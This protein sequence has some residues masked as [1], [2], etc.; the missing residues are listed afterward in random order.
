MITT[1]TDGSCADNTRSHERHMVFPLSSRR[2][3]SVFINQL[4]AAMGLPTKASAAEV[5]LIIEGRLSDDEREPSNVQVVAKELEDGSGVHLQLQDIDGIFL[6]APPIASTDEA[7]SESSE[8]EEA[9]SVS[10]E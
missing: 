5:L 4:A 2:L 8:E 10:A 3:T 6:E 1:T 7:I 9:G